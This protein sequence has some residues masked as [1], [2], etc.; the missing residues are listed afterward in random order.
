MSTAEIFYLNCDALTGNAVFEKH[1]SEMPTERQEKINRIKF[2]SDKRL[3]LGAGILLKMALGEYAEGAMLKNEHGKPYIPDCPLKFSIS[4]S[5]NYAVVATAEC[6]IGC[7]IQEI[8]AE[9]SMKIADRFFRKSEQDYILGGDS[10]ERF[11]RLWVLKESYI[12]ALGT[13]LAT[14]LDSF[15][16]AFENDKPYIKENSDYSLA[17]FHIADGYRFAVCAKG[18]PAFSIKRI[19][20]L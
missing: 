10:E 19:E 14:P 9:P 18:S 5:G 4:H 1:Y 11:F 16:I 17:E 13:G 2:D 15:E 12:K 6:E 20:L 7:D 3:S 8:K